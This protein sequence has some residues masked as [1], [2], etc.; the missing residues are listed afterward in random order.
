M[1]KKRTNKT[2]IRYIDQGDKTTETEDPTTPDTEEGVT[3][4]QDN[5]STMSTE[6]KKSKG[7]KII[8]EGKVKKITKQ[9]KHKPPD[10][11]HIHI[12]HI[13]VYLCKKIHIS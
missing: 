8:T 9:K 11:L 12:L 6:D 3:T 10:L 1:S 2:T 13:Y 5:T 4:S 7:P